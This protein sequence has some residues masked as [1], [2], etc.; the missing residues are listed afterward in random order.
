MGPGHIMPIDDN[1]VQSYLDRATECFE[2]AERTQDPVERDKLHKIAQ[3]YLRL[4]AHIDRLQL[5]RRGIL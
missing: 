5:I 3:G 2:A 4:A 1:G